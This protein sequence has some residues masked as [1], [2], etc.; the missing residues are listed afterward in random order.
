MT[1]HAPCRAL[2]LSGRCFGSF[3]S[4]CGRRAMRG[5]SSAPHRSRGVIRGPRH[6][7]RATGAPWPRDEEAGPRRDRPSS[8]F[9]GR[10]KQAH[11]G[12]VVDGGADRPTAAA[13]SPLMATCQNTR[14][15]PRGPVITGPPHWHLSA[16]RA[17]T[18][19]ARDMRVPNSSLSPFDSVGGRLNPLILQHGLHRAHTMPK[20]LARGVPLHGI[21]HSQPGGLA[22][23]QTSLVTPFLREPGQC[24]TGRAG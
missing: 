16:R 2:S 19:G 9:R 18:I 15:P 8:I 13:S 11:G 20:Q 5:L 1:L 3:G 6:R 24:L 23:N 21:E 17:T 22:L 14:G 10:A 7:R 12:T 4:G